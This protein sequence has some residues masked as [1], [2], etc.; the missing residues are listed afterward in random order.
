MRLSVVRAAVVLVGVAFAGGAGCGAG[1]PS[2]VP[3]NGALVPVEQRVAID[4]VA[5]EDLVEP[6]KALS[7]NDF[8]GEVVV[9]NVWGTW[10]GPCRGEV[11]KLERVRA[12]TEGAG[13]EFLG[14][15]IRDN[16]RSVPVD[17]V[18]DR[19]VGY[20]SIYDPAG[21]SLV[22]L[23]KYRS[24]AVPTTLV[25]DRRHRVA[26]VFHGAVL[27]EDVLPRVREVVA[28]AVG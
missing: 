19:G 21:R 12:D 9:L 20:P 5:G 3:V 11:G 26:A 16:D 22:G 17:F 14:V 25:L 13:V 24:I 15:D 8:A 6:G 1:N 2:A 4:A 10:C 7:S 18:R 27:A 23:G 28:E